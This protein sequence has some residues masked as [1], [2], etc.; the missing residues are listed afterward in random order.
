M[1]LVIATPVFQIFAAM[2]IGLF[3][4]QVAKRL[5]SQSQ[6]PIAVG[7]NDGLSFLTS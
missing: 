5:S 3:L 4:I 6:N 2:I 1:R 7:I